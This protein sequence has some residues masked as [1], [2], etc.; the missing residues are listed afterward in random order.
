MFTIGQTP[1]PR[2]RAM[3]AAYAASRRPVLPSPDKMAAQ[4]AAFVQKSVED[5]MHERAELLKQWRQ[6][7]L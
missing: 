1:K 5:F 3:H 2:A 6:R 7:R 4:V